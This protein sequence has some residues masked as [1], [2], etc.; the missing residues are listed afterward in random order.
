MI[1]GV[2]MLIF[3]LGD[4]PSATPVRFDT[5]DLCIAA[6]KAAL[7]EIKATQPNA[8][9]VITCALATGATPR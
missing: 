3:M 4:T 2:V 5:M 6:K 8:S 9:A 1:G 7:A